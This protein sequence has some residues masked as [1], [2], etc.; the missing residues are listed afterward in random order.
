MA[1]G[2]RRARS[3]VLG[4]SLSPDRGDAPNPLTREGAD[5]EA[6]ITEAR[7]RTTSR[8][9]LDR[10]PR[11]QQVSPEVG[12]LDDAAVEEA[13]H[14]DPDEMLAL[15]ADLA[16]A[17]DQSLR[18]SARRL[19]VRLFLDL[20]RRGPSARRGIGKITAQPYRPDG[21]DLD[22]DASFDV[23]AEAAAARAAVD[24]ERLRVRSW[25]TPDTAL[26]LLV[27]RS[28]SMGGQP[29]ATAAITAAAVAI[30]NSA[31]YSVLAFGK[32]V[33]AVKSQG[34]D[35]ATE[36]VVTDVLTLRGHG[37]TDLA[38]ALRAA[39]EQLGRS[40]AARKIV[41]L[42]SDCRATVEGDVRSAAAALSELVIIAPAQDCDEAMRLAHDCGARLATVAGPFQAAEALATVLER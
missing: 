21:G 1:A 19:A 3:G 8:R 11:F 26:C 12:Q 29:L 35:K 10:N 28:G 13:V 14:E 32:D 30:R 42:L 41:I 33:V 37:T 38:G 5:A 17:T 24:F 25:S 36:L 9:E 20:A 4:K 7:K 39:G 27:D 34:A 31:S 23:I 16:A 40:K 2:V 22:L 6:A 15:L 18:E